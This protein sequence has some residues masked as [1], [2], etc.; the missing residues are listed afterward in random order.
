[1]QETVDRRW[2][3]GVSRDKRQERGDRRRESGEMRQ[4]M[5]DGSQETGDKR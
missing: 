3:T 5:G 2:E 4:K 1:M